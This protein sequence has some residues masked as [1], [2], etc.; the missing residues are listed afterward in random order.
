[1]DWTFIVIT[2]LGLVGTGMNEM[3]MSERQ[4]KKLE[5][6]VRV[7]FEQARTENPDF[8]FILECRPN[9]ER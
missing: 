9:D 3:P 8:G 5:A 6:R 2:W 1:M 7:V 4:C